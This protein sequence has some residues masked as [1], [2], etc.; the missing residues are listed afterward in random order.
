MN[1]RNMSILCWNVCGLGDANKCAM[2]KDIIKEANAS[3]LCIQETK[4]SEMSFVK[5]NTIAPPR[6]TNYSMLPANGSRGEP[7]LHGHQPIPLTQPTP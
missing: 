4:L 2:V 6:Y 1:V 5:F 3:I 7:S